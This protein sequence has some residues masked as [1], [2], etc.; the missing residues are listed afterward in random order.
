MKVKKNLPNRG[1]RYTANLP[2]EKFELT[3]NH[4][5]TLNSNRKDPAPSFSKVFQDRSIVQNTE[6]LSDISMFD[7]YLK[8]GC[9][10]MY[11]QFL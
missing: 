11:N 10:S 1:I 3:A 2:K 8:R 5:A 7:R 9:D 6:S 4:F